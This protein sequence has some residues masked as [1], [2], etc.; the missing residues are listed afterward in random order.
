[1]TEPTPEQITAALTSG[2]LA[3]ELLARANNPGRTYTSDEVADMLRS[4]RMLARMRERLGN[5]GLD[6]YIQEATDYET[7][8]DHIIDKLNPS[9]DDAAEVS[10][11]CAAIDQ[12]VGYI[13]AQPCTCPAGTFEDYG[14]PCPRCWALMRRENKPMDNS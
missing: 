10:I 1:M 12:A 4:H 14:D 3:D 9:D 13:E 7:L 11:L 8:R 2:P 5:R 6:S